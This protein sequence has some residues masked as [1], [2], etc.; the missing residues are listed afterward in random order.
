MLTQAQRE[1]IKALKLEKERALNEAFLLEVR[2][3]RLAKTCKHPLELQDRW[4][5]NGCL[6]WNRC[7]ICLKVRP[8]V[9]VCGDVDYG[10][11]K[12]IKD[13]MI[14][15]CRHQAAAVS[16]YK[17][18]SDNGYGRQ[19]MQ[20]GE[21]CSICRA[22]KHWKNSSSWMSYAEQERQAAFRREEDRW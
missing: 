20:T 12:D 6:V 19:S 3:L 9:I 14:S 10:T 11:E 13:I 4:T 15:F 21:R 5:Y 22:E 18:E 1:Y 8:D 17:W 2:R 16:E 7:K